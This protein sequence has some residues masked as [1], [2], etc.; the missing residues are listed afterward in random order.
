M[1]PVAVALNTMHNNHWLHLDIKSE[2]ILI[3][4]EGLAVLGDLGISQHYDESGKKITKG[5]G[6]GTQGRCS[7]LQYDM[8]YTK[9]FHPELDIFSFAA[10]MYYA[11]TGNDMR[12]FSPNDLDAPFIEISAKSKKALRKAL[13]Q[14]LETTPKSVR[15]FMHML[16][17]CEKMVF[18]DIQPVDIDLSLTEEDLEPNNFEDLPYFT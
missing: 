1:K 6:V 15:E 3:D 16:P 14:N 17:G 2:N 12:H 4:D 7:H 8:E 9:Q 18:E 10:L 11:M 5:G 13:D